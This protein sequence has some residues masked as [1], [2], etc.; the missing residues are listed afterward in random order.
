MFVHWLKGTM[1]RELCI[2]GTQHRPITC[3]GHVLYVAV[4][5]SLGV[6]IVR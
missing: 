6:N 4:L 5:V 3:G 2:A 1:D